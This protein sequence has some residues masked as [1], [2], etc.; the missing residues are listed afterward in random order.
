MGEGASVTY[1]RGLDSQGES[2]CDALAVDHVHRL[3]LSQ[4]RLQV[5]PP[6]LFLLYRSQPPQADAIV[7]GRNNFYFTSV[8]DAP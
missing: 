1:L 8:R 6:L 3:I 5:S 4:L 7:A 2:E